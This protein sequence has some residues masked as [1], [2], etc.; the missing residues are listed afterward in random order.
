MAGTIKRK[1]RELIVE[2]ELNLRNEFEVFKV[3]KGYF[4]SPNW[5]ASHRDYKISRMN[6][7]W[8]P[9]SEVNRP[10][11]K[12]VEVNLVRHHEL[13]LGVRSLFSY[14]VAYYRPSNGP[15]NKGAFGSTGLLLQRSSCG[16]PPC[17][18]FEVLDEANRVDGA[19]DTVFQC[20]SCHFPQ[21]RSL[22][23]LNRQDNVGVAAQKKAAQQALETALKTLD[24]GDFVAFATGDFRRTEQDGGGA[25]Y[26]FNIG[27]VMPFDKNDDDEVVVVGE[28]AK[29]GRRSELQQEHRKGDTLVRLRTFDRFVRKESRTFQQ[30]RHVYLLN[31]KK[32]FLMAVAASELTE[33]AKPFEGKDEKDLTVSELEALAHWTPTFEMSTALNTEIE[34][35][36]LARRC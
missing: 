20:A 4:D 7:T 9:E 32:S 26:S 30:T 36:A 29:A 6:V 17:T 31:L 3:I 19:A 15:A 22:C 27:R 10:P 8:L 33:M 34:Q 5:R 25:K 35:I 2:K 28:A 11:K 18:T 1:L 14:A 24:V 23:V 21:R 12:S 13:S 16:C